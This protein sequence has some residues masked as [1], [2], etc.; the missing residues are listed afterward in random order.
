MLVMSVQS[1]YALWAPGAL[2]GTSNLIALILLRFLP[3]TMG[4]E[5]PQ[6]VEDVKPKNQALKS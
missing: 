1:R 3:E 4:K 6:T 5:L 2:F